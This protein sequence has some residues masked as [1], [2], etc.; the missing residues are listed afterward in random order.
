MKKILSLFLLVCSVFTFSL[1]AQLGMGKWRTHFAYNSVYKVAQ[2]DNKIFAVS[3]GALFSVDKSEASIQQYSRVT[4]LNDNVV[5]QI[6]YDQAT[7]QL[8][9]AYQNGN[10]DLLSDKGIVNIPDYY[11]KAM[12]VDKNI[13]HIYIHNNKAY[14]S[15]NFG[16]IVLDLGKKAITESYYIG[17]N[18]SEVI[19]TNTTVY[20]NNLYAL[21]Y[22]ET[23]T[24]SS[25]QKNYT[26]FYG[27]LSNP[28][29]VNYE[30]WNTMAGLPG[31]GDMKKFVSFQDYLFLLRD[32][33]LYSKEGSGAWQPYQLAQN[34]VVLSD[35]VVIDIDGSSSVFVGK[36]YNRVTKT[37]VGV[38]LDAAYEIR[39]DTY[40]F[41]AESKGLVGY[42]YDGSVA[43][44]YY[45]PEGPATNNGWDMVFDEERLYVVP[46][47]RDAAQMQRPGYVMIY[48]NDEWNN[49]TFDL[50]WVQPYD[51]M[52][53]TVDPKDRSRYFV[54]SY[55]NG[56]FEVKN[57]QLVNWFTPSNTDGILTSVLP[58]NPNYYT[59][60]SGGVFDAQ[61]NFWCLNT[62]SGK[63][64]KVF[65]AD[66]KW[67]E[68]SSNGINNHEMIGKIHIDKKN[69]NRKWF[70]GER[71]KPLISVL[72]DKG[73]LDDTN[74]DETVTYQSFISGKETLAPGSIYSIAQEAGGTIWVG[75]DMGPI[76]FY[77]PENILTSSACSRVLIPRN[78]GTNEA[79]ALLAGESILSIAIDG[80]NR[81]WLGT[82]NSGAYL[83]SENGQETVQHFTAENSPLL[84]D[85]VF[86]VAINP[87][88]GEVFFATGNGLISYQSDAADAGGDFKDVHVYPN[89][90]R[91]T[92]SG[93][94]TI[95]GLMEK[96]Q[97]KITDLN[98]NL[99]CETVSNGSLATW[100][101]KD[102]RGRRVAT[103]VY[104]ALCMSEDGKK[105]T[106]A[107]ILVIN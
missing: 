28:N 23:G 92:Y 93:L 94:I 48:E 33:V 32:G 69:K 61:G 20:D 17:P 72:D 38:V 74:D 86:S 47:G 79:D 60:T 25:K 49:I 50:G 81:K 77:Q 26:V 34:V 37:G 85:R 13:N 100:D 21:T 5:S 62:K 99:I 58:Q 39:N 82:R 90:V 103:G 45:I 24:G 53:V 76:L 9:I 41:A 80:G 83:V 8:I 105:S 101:G 46:G 65:T 1:Y 71:M 44:A 96:T 14:L 70:L 10:I 95:T 68:L 67:I 7:R 55:G 16:I 3:N 56:V 22:V 88:T 87:K 64:V 102:G 6:E 12:S 29:L 73:T 27:S 66:R 57:N 43:P 42:K 2:T 18:A 54:T 40:W 75:T 97:V 4:G 11:A 36:D 35:R 15:C 106:I 51:F 84:S 107:K 89:P 63:G 104:L 59:R 52:Q 98:G 78:D 91:E 19:V 31:T 30:N